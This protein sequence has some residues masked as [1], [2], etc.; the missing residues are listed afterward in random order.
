MR[1]WFSALCLFGLYAF[2]DEA[3][4][5]RQYSFEEACR[6]AG[7]T[8]GACAPKS[9]QPQSPACVP[10]VGKAFHAEKAPANDDC[11]K[12]TLSAVGNVEVLVELVG[13]PN[14]PKVNEFKVTFRQAPGFGNAA[15][16]F[17]EGNRLILH[18]PEWAKSVTA[19]A[20]LVLAHEVG[21]HFCGHTLPGFQS[22]PKVAELEADR[23]SGASIKRFE[24]YH[25]RAF[26]AA[27]LNAANTL[28]L[29]N[30]S[31]AHPARRDRV[32]AVLEGYKN[33]SPCGGLAP[34]IPGY[35]PNPR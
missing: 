30:G 12:T 13:L 25:N 10:L 18:D 19:E 15:A 21:H 17:H 8:T 24:I 16:L 11:I 34:A 27:A 6:N 5:Q 2:V 31:R 26:L 29:E 33:D 4:A 32:A 14:I 1:I 7:W 3:A 9:Q 20:Y 22:N 28:Y 23:F 35:S